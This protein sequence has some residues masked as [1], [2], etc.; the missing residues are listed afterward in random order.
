ML[1]AGVVGVVMPKTTLPTVV[2]CTFLATELLPAGIT[3]LAPAAP[4]VLP[5]QFTVGV[6]VAVKVPSEAV[7]LF[8]PGWRE[9]D[10]MR[11]AGP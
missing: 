6:P 2:T 8:G 5:S 11:K 4:P 7:D 9:R 1:A 10:P 3:K